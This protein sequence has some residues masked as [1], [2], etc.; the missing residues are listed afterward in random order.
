MKIAGNFNGWNNGADVMTDVDGDTIYTITKSLTPGD[1][2]FFKFIK[3]ADGWENDPNRQY[4]S[5]S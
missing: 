3:G 5:T 4:S 2:L 1:T